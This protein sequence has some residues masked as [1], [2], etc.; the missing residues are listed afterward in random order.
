MAYR[1]LLLGLLCREPPICRQREA[2]WVVASSSSSG[3]TE[4]VSLKVM[5]ISLQVFSHS[6]QGLFV[7][8]RERLS[9]SLQLHIQFRG[10]SHIQTF[11]HHTKVSIFLQ[12]FFSSALE[13]SCMWE[14]SA[15][16]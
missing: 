5:M 8:V 1:G 14:H 2:T 6:G 12:G 3:D 16:V 7:W 13:V 10:V 15:T 11:L 4:K 9:E